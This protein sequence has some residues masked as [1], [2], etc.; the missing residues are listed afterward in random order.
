MASELREG[1]LKAADGD[2][3]GSLSFARASDVE[4]VIDLYERG[5]VRA[6]DTYRQFRASGIVPMGGCPRRCF[7]R[8]VRREVDYLGWGPQ[9]VPTIMA[10]LAYAEAHCRPKDEDG[11]D[12]EVTLDFDAGGNVF[13]YI[14]E[15]G[16]RA[17]LPE[18]ST[19]FEF[20][21]AFESEERLRS[22]GPL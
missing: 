9:E 7:T 14:E 13:S 22:E 17:A 16:L 4:V 5:F 19:K 11:R 15:V 21:F 3:D 10:A 18:R 6:F 1:A 2:V 8:G 12:A 20:A